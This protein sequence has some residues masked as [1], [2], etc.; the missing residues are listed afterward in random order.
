MRVISC[1][2]AAPAV[3]P[4]ATAEGGCATKCSKSPSP[5]AV[6]EYRERGERAFRPRQPVTRRAFYFSAAVRYIMP[7]A[8]YRGA[9]EI[10]LNRIA[11][12]FNRSNS[13]EK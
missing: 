8:L 3:I 2:T 9:C 10:K 13:L 1:G 4:G 11:R 7:I 5:Y 6:P 12:D